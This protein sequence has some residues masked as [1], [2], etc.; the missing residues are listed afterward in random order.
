MAAAALPLAG[1]DRW[2][3]WSDRPIVGLLRQIEQREPLHADGSQILGLDRLAI[4]VMNTTPAPA[5]TG[6]LCNTGLP[7][8]VN[9]VVVTEFF[10]DGAGPLED[11]D[12]GIINPAFTLPPFVVVPTDH[13]GI[14]NWVTF[15][16]TL[17]QS[18]DYKIQNIE[19]L[20]SGVTFNSLL[21]LTFT[22]VPMNNLAAFHAHLPP[23]VGGCKAKLP[24]RLDSKHCCL[25]ILNDD[26]QCLRCCILCHV[27]QI[28]MYA[29][30]GAES[31]EAMAERVTHNKN[32]E[33]WNNYLANP[34]NGGP[35]PKNWQP[36]YKDCG[37]DFS[38]L[39]LDRGSS[40]DDIEAL[41]LANPELAI[42]VYIYKECIV[43]HL[44][45]DFVLLR[46]L[47]Q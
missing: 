44:K 23:V 39:P 36:V 19:G 34:R 11:D 32:A 22:F 42:F 46:R 24:K 15:L 25:S 4:P 14:S 37:V 5:Y 16:A 2:S 31:K 47:P 18:I 3:D 10:R 28:Y 30:A 12:D 21:A 35:K 33:R 6:Q 29:P 40:L 45:E 41:E 27:L 17:R 43:E 13:D 38:S 9:V 8:R 26:D 1:M 7:F 20:P